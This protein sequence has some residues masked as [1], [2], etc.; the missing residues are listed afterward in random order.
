MSGNDKSIVYLAGMLKRKIHL[1][2]ADNLIL[3]QEN[4]YTLVNRYY[5]F[6]EIG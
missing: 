1:L 6:T 5:N 3:F 2:I 4:Q